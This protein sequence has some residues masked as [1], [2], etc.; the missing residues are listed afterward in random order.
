VYVV[1][2]DERLR[3]NVKLVTKNRKEA[4]ASYMQSNDRLRGQGFTCMDHFEIPRGKTKLYVRRGSRDV[5]I[6]MVRFR[7]FDVDV[8][9]RITAW[10][11]KWAKEE[12][13]A[14]HQVPERVWPEVRGRTI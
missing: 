4:F 12:R 10:V 1:E 3:S 6:R 5:C 13:P 2:V 8:V 11:I 9:V 14:Q 7:K